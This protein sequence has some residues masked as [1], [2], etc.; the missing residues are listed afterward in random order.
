[1]ANTTTTVVVGPA[2]TVEG[3]LVGNA[4]APSETA[5]IIFAPCRM[6]PSRSTCVPIMNP[7]TS[8]KN[9]SGTLNA[10]HV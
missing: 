8:A 7:G 2:G 6:M 4:T 1:M 3:D 9:S 10:L 5:L